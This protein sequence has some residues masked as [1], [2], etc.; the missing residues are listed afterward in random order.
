MII[1]G[2]FLHEKMKKIDPRKFK[3]FIYLKLIFIYI[4]QLKTKVFEYLFVLAHKYYFSTK[5]LFFIQGKP[6]QTCR[7]LQ[8]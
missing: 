6:R 5:I 7:A 3:T 4:T 1:W 8:K 2:F